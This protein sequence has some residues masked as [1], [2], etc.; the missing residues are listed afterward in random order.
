[1]LH[2]RERIFV[3]IAA[4]RDPELVPTL[5]DCIARADR[6]DL[7]SFGIAWQRSDED[8][9]AEFADDP[10]LRVLDIDY[11]DSQG[12]CWARHRLQQLY[13]GEAFNLAIDSHARFEPGWDT[14]LKAQL[15]SCAS[16]KPVLTAYVA[17]YN[18]QDDGARDPTPMYMHY[19]AWPD[20]GML[21]FEGR[22][23]K[24]HLA[25]SAPAPARFFSAH[26]TFAR[27]SF[28][29]DC[30]HD[31]KLYFHGEEI[32]L[33][34]RAFTHGYDLFHP[35]RTTVY[36]LYGRAGRPKHWGDHAFRPGEAIGYHLKDY[37][38]KRRVRYLLGME[39]PE[40]PVDFGPYGLGA[41]RSLA[42]Y[43]RYTGVNFA[44]RSLSDAARNGVPLAAI[45]S[46]G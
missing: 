37:L 20:N 31:P 10:R 46:A 44:A 6:P 34:V 24:N 28:L 36:H 7:L 12:A 38:A 16:P 17:P 26:F 35:H 14:Q 43:E 21:M 32:S 30:G 13:Q 4:Y 25:W 42:D 18:P 29:A 33:A 5:R 23:I 45:F 1:M 19:H 9:L 39:T 11:R 2:G 22:H 8:S 41:E 15:A 40:L 27:G 3:Q